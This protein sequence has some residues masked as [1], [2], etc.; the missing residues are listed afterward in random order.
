MQKLQE[1]VLYYHAGDPK[2]ARTL[3]GML[4]RL[5]IRIRKVEPEQVLESVGYLAGMPGYEPASERVSGE[6]CVE[7]G[8]ENAGTGT[9]KET[10]TDMEKSSKAN[11]SKT[12]SREIPIIPESV[13]VMRNFTSSRMDFL[14]YNLRK[15]KLPPIPMKAVVTPT[16]AGWSF[17]QLYEELKEEHA[18]MHG[19]KKEGNEND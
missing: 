15:A 7:E 13:L 12:N 5:G 4:I 11:S 18:R 19:M 3:Y 16:N 8:R 17:Y 9:E 6:A 2:D 1:T 14:L 10:E